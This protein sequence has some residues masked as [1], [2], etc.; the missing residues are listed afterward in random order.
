MSVSLI[1]LIV[2]GICF[3]LEAFHVTV[4]AITPKWWALGVAFYLFSQAAG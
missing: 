3:V 2:A 1:L 4:G